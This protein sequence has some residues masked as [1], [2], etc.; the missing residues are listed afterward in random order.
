MVLLEHGCFQ[1]KP[2]GD[3]GHIQMNSTANTHS[4]EI[5]EMTLGFHLVREREAQFLNVDL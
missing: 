1:I 3:G 5:L 4:D 2:T